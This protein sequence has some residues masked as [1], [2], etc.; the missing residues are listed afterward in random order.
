MVEIIKSADTSNIEAI[1]HPFHL[2]QHLRADNITELDQ[3]EDFSK[4]APLY[5]SDH[6]LVPKVIG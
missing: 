2:E 3:S 6:Y 1:S 5:E 4:L